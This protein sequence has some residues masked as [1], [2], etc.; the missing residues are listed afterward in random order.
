MYVCFCSCLFCLLLFIF[1]QFNTHCL[2]CAR[3][4]ARISRTHIHTH[5]K[6]KTCSSKAITDILRWVEFHMMLLRYCSAIE[7]NSS[8]R[9][10][11]S[12]SDSGRGNGRD[13]YTTSPQLQSGRIH[14][15]YTYIFFSFCSSSAALSLTLSLWHRM[16][17]LVSE[18]FDSVCYTIKLLL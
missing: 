5:Q 14:L 4:H 17:L 3:T 11:D 1:I 2:L 12:D 15:F 8:D 10:S 6:K 9:S 13:S 7:I 16:C 18:R